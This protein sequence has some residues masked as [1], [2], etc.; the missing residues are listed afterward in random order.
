MHNFS[1][2]SMNSKFFFLH[3]KLLFSKL[4]KWPAIKKFWIFIL[5]SKYVL[6]IGSEFVKKNLDNN[7]IQHNSSKFIH[8]V[9]HEHLLE[10]MRVDRDFEKRSLALACKSVHCLYIYLYICLYEFGILFTFDLAVIEIW[11]HEVES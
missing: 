4:S 1:D 8:T 11:M 3:Y 10:R 5:F 7:G 6:S 9:Y 2:I